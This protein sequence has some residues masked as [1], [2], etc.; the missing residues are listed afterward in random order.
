MI[1]SIAHSKGGVGKTTTAMNIAAV[2]KPALI[3]DQ[4]LHQGLSVLNRQRSEPFSLLAGHSGEQ[5]V[6]TLREASERGDLIIID[7][8]GFDSDINRKAIAASDLVI[9]PA[10]DSPTEVVGLQTFDNTLSEIAAQFNIEINAR[11]LLTRVHHARKSFADIEQFVGS[12][13]T[14]RMLS[15]KLPNRSDYNSALYQGLGV[16]EHGPTKYGA[17]ARDINNLVDEIKSSV[18]LLE[19]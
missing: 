8:G 9:V 13:K 12:S 3:I 6:A 2:L 14:M 15:A 19:A 7:C 5:L 11:V 10:N 18:A 1:I 4:D 17:A 16:T